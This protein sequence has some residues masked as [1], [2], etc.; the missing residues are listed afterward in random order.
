MAILINALKEADITWLP[1]V[2]QL[3]ARLGRPASLLLAYVCSRVD[4]AGLNQPPWLTTRRAA[5]ALGMHVET[6]Q[7]A[8]AKLEQEG[9][10]TFTLNA[11]RQRLDIHLHF[12]AVKDLVAFLGDEG[13]PVQNP[14]PPSPKGSP[15]RNPPPSPVQDPPGSPV[16]NPPPSPVQ[17]PPHI[18]PHKPGRD[19]N[20]IPP[21]ADGAS[22]LKS[23]RT[24]SQGGASPLHPSAY[25]CAHCFT[26]FWP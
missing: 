3:E 8:R 5:T 25:H 1:H 13:S 6:V 20:H 15:V 17:N 26:R 2:P 24:A 7:R 23:S 19:L 9:L 18:N 4:L 10:V 16:E 11:E 22:P 12:D 14:P 21:S